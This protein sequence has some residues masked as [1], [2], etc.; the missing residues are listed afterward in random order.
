VKL[1]Y[2]IGMLICLISLTGTALA[3]D[4]IVL[5]I[6]NVGGAAVAGQYVAVSVSPISDS[7]YK[8]TFITSPKNDP[9]GD[10]YPQ[11]W[12]LVVGLPEGADV[13]DNNAVT[14]KYGNHITGYELETGNIAGFKEDGVQIIFTI[15]DFTNDVKSAKDNFSVIHVTFSGSFD[16]PIS[17]VWGAHV[18]WG[19]DVIPGVG[20]SSAKFMGYGG[21]E[22]TI[23][24]FPSIALP[25]AAILG[26]M[27]I[28]GR[29]KQE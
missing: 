24:E 8:A 10:P 7:Q 11:G 9:D 15:A 16:D 18:A 6:D 5:D 14:D 25:V 20:D 27:F 23:P 1:K 21:E 26:I 28:F 22:T 4:P 17:P 29:K 12:F 2:I 3:A 13:A 19:E